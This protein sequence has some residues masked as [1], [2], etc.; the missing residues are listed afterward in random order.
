M[1][2]IEKCENFTRELRELMDKYQLGVFIDDC[3]GL[4]I[5]NIERDRTERYIDE[6]LEN[7]ARK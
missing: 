4:E 1:I 7:T 3:Q 5:A 6:L 2:C